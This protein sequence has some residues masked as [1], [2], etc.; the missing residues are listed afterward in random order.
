MDR[1][2]ALNISQKYVKLVAQ[3]FEFEKAFM[4]G[5]FAKDNADENSDI[6]IAIILKEYKD[7]FETQLELMKIRRRV[8]L[9][10]EP[11]LILKED[12][13]EENP[14]AK[15]IL[16]NGIELNNNGKNQKDFLTVKTGESA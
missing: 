13:V 4:F 15:E 10:I 2:K 7:F 3:E 16:K 6:D 8:D 12:F 1:I 9:R 11:H 5:S 14:L